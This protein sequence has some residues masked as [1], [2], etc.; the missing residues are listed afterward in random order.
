M[1]GYDNHLYFIRIFNKYTGMSPK[2]YRNKFYK[3][4]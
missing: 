1:D 3:Q 2:E 4:S